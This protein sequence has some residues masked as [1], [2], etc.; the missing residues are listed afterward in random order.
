MKAVGLLKLPRSSFGEG[1]RSF[2][3]SGGLELFD[4]TINM[5]CYYENNTS[6]TAFPITKWIQMS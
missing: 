6:S 3:T 5:Y 1:L 2:H 4:D